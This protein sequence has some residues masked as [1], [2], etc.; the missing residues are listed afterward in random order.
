MDMPSQTKILLVIEDIK[1]LDFIALILIGENYKV[2]SCHNQT[3]ALNLLNKEKPD[4]IIVDFF[5]SDMNGLSFCKS[6]KNNIRFRFT[7]ILLVLPNDE[8]LIK[9]KSIYADADEFINAPFSSEEL[10]TR[11]KLTLWKTYRYQDMHPLTKLPGFAAAVKKIERIKNERML[12]IAWAGLY[13][14]KSFN[15]YYDFKRG[16]E[17]LKHTGLLINKALLDLGSETDFLSHI[18]GDNFIII[19]SSESIEEVCEKVIEEFQETIPSFYDKEDRDKGYILVKD[20]KG[21]MNEIPLLR[22]HLGVVT[23]Q[24]Y[25]FTCSAQVFEIAIELKNYAKKFQKST[26]IKDRRKSY[27]F[28]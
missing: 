28:Y 17:V 21:E 9:T 14:L 13:K 11:I 24:F 23:N 26:Y 1:L 2:S 7:P 8:S 5:S 16:N 12:G 3:D 6:A 20:R 27:P 10:F 15:K 18:G 25:T 4:L 22:M 19:S